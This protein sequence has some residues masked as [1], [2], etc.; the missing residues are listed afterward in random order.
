MVTSGL[1][2]ELACINW[3][4]KAVK[5]TDLATQSDRPFP[6]TPLS[7]ISDSPSIRKKNNNPF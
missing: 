6:H 4:H 7:S 5:N 1:Y 2:P 3:T